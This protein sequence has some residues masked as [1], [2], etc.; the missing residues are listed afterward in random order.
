MSFG[1]TIRTDKIS[2]EDIDEWRKMFVDP[3]I[4]N[5]YIEETKGAWAG[6]TEDSFNLVVVTDAPD[7]VEGVL[8]EI[9]ISYKIKFKQDAVIV[10]KV[11]M[12][13]FS[14]L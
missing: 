14:K 1:K 4:E 3:K 9:G 11:C 5:Y 10:T 12:A 8:E 7:E 6:T 13:M 2:Q